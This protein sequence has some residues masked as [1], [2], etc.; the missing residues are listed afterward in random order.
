[1]FHVFSGHVTRSGSVAQNHSQNVQCATQGLRPAVNHFS[2][3]IALDLGYFICYRTSQVILRSFQSAAASLP[4]FSFSP[5]QVSLKSRGTH[6]SRNPSLLYSAAGSVDILG[7]VF[8]AR[9]RQGETYGVFLW[10]RRDDGRSRTPAFCSRGA[11]S[12][13]AGFAAL[14][15]ALQ[16]TSVHPAAVAGGAVPDA[17]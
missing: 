4:H 13:H 5:W 9:G 10:G 12:G 3:N 6:R 11:A 15:H 7:T 2:A 14:P 17:L 8:V 16:Q 1:M